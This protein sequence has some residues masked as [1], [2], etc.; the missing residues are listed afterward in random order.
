MEKL[1]RKQHQWSLLTKAIG[2]DLLFWGCFV[3]QNTA[4]AM[5][6]AVSFCFG[7]SAQAS[8]KQIAPASLNRAKPRPA[9]SSKK[10]G[11]MDEKSEETYRDLIQKAQN[12][13]LQQDRLQT[14]QILI[15]GIQR[16]NRGSQAYRE[17]VR[18]LDN[19][20]GVFYTEKAQNLFAHAESVADTKSREAI[21]PF[22]EAIKAEDRN[23]TVLKA[24]ARLHLRLE[25]CDKADIR[26]KQ[27]EEVNP[28]SAEIRLLRLQTFACQKNY[29]MLATRLAAHDT[30]LDPVEAYARG[31]HLLDLVT[32]KELKKAKTLI[33]TWESQSPDYPEVYYWKWQLSKEIGVADRLPAMR[34]SE[35]CQSLTTRKRKIFSLDVDLCKGK[36]VVDSFLKEKESHGSGSTTED[37][38]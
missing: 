28:Y 6:I 26:V 17:L 14:S 21:E 29:E 11:V 31:L 8:T 36:A 23:V 19:L 12:L 5:T 2:K 10:T 30:D 7:L 18:A 9:V 35:L 4:I 22:Q 20:T 38:N 13:T 37:A 27:A 24:V 32:R 33:A 34:Y 25:E 1:I 15:R 16:E 3:A